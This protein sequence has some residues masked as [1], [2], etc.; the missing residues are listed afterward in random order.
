MSATPHVREAIRLILAVFSLICFGLF[1]RTSETIGTPGEAST[2]TP[3]RP[4]VA[5]PHGDFDG[6][7]GD[8]HSGDA[9]KPA[10]ISPDF[11]HAKFGFPLVAAHRAVECF[12]CHASLEFSQASSECSS[13]H[14]DVHKGSFGADCWQC[15]GTRTFLDRS[16]QIAMH[17]VTQFPLTGSHGTLD[18]DQCHR[19]SGSSMEFITQ[20]TQCYGCHDE[21]YASASSPNHSQAG[22][23]TDCA[24]CH[25][26]LS[27]AGGEYGG[28]HSFFPLSGGHAGVECQDCHVSGSFSAVDR[29]CFACHQQD[30]DA[31]V[32]PVHSAAGFS[33]DCQACHSINSWNG[34]VFDHA[35]SG[36]PLTGAHVSVD[37]TDCHTQPSYAA[38]SSEC[39]A[40]HQTDYQGATDPNHA[41]AGFPTDCEQ[42]HSTFTW[43]GANFDHSLSNFPLTGAHRA[44]ECGA[45]HANG[46]FSGTPTDCYPCHQAE[47]A[48]TSDPAHSAAGFSIQCQDCHSTIAWMPATFDH[49]QT[50][51]PLTGAHLAADCTQCHVGGVYTGTST[52]CYACHRPEYD[53]TANPVHAPA[54]FGTDCASCHNTSG[55]EGA[56]FDHDSNWFPINSGKHRNEWNECTDCHTNPS[57]YSVYTCF[58]C[59]PHSDKAKTD[60]DHRGENGYSYVSSE[61]YRCHPQGT[62]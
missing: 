35:T 47:F 61:C 8:C 30:Y 62:H 57:N 59:H 54:G 22:F 43:D 16:E 41:S 44:V 42:C 15:H 39:F 40:C 31:T 58:N 45:C 50:I 49:G 52:D 4:E 11:D 24:E 14:A 13:C 55:W 36:F 29:E 10:A 56:N 19:S 32:D 28:D 26:T 18:C 1:F 6:D 46:V 23:S 21:D 7:C 9:W 53:A 34:A 27:W 3:E 20:S 60:G 48:S 37:C 12:A 2:P 33:T 38:T 51:F 5:Y 17:R 25:G